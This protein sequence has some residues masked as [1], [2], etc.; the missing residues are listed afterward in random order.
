MQK[1]K[2]EAPNQKRLEK[3]RNVKVQGNAISLNL[4]N[5]NPKSP[6]LKTYK[7]FYF[8]LHSLREAENG[9]IYS[10]YCK[11]KMCPNCN[12]MKMAKNIRMYAQPLAELDECTFVTL[13][14]KNP[15]GE[16]LKAELDKMQNAW[17]LIYQQSKKA[18]YKKILSPLRGFKKLECHPSKKSDGTFHPH[19]HIVV[20][21]KM[22]AEWLI[23]QWLKHFPT[24]SG[25]CQHH[26][27]AYGE[28][29]TLEAF[30]YATKPTVSAKIHNLEYYYNQL[31]I[32]FQALKNKQCFVPFG[33]KAVKEI[34][35]E[36]EI[37]DETEPTELIK[38]V[39]TFL[40]DDWYDKDTGEAF[41]KTPVPNKIKNRY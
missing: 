18:K 12:R 23:E 11:T 25:K 5:F 9:K 41:V 33:I 6:L 10:T 14:V 40:N 31:D 27:V 37:F 8:C 1:Y 32:C 2:K 24:A 28:N 30:K 34:I 29:P 19:Y 13:T 39:L 7:N 36:K 16:N 15:T 3:K 20:N 21:D 22:Q 17:R 35:E 38:S 26:V 4:Q